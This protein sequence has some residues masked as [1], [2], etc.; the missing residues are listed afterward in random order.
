MNP[1]LLPYVW[2]TEIREY[3]DSWICGVADSLEVAV[4]AVRRVDERSLISWDELVIDD[5]DNAH[6]NGHFR[7]VM[8]VHIIPHSLN[9]NFGQ[10]LR[11]DECCELM[12]QASSLVERAVHMADAIFDLLEDVS[13]ESVN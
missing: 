6:L 3:S 7:F 8:G 12:L 10:R 9:A 5:E 11:Y 2:I 4:A 1:E 13:K